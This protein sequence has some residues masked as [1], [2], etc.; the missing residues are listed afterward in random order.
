MP[1]QPSSSRLIPVD[2]LRGLI[3]IFMA[4]DHAGYF[5]ARVHISDWWGIPLPQYSS[6]LAF[7]T[8]FVTHPCAPGF[9]FLLAQLPQLDRQIYYNQHKYVR[10]STTT[11][12]F[13]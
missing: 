12:S 5:V 11:G 6:P 9:F 4:L 10:V 13:R 8:R 3:M 1:S 7:L 2:A